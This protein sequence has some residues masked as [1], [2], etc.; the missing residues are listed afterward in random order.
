MNTSKKKLCKNRYEKARPS[1]FWLKCMIVAAA[2]LSN[3]TSG[4]TTPQSENQAISP[5]VITQTST[6]LG[7]KPGAI[8]DDAFIQK[9]ERRNLA[10][11]SGSM[12]TISG[13]G[14]IA[15]VTNTV[16]VQAK[17]SSGVN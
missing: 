17:T 5:E 8:N 1:T 3:F 11:T 9:H 16:T 6:D 7:I 10:G 12:S 4:S 13:V 14:L 2:W 15:G